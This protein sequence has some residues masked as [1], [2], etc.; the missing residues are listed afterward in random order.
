MLTLTL[1]TGVTL[2][3]LCF[4]VYALLA[5]R[6]LGTSAS[7]GHAESWYAA[8]LFFAVYSANKLVQGGWGIAAFVAGSDAPV[9]AG[10]LRFA[11]VFNHSRTFLTFVLYGTLFWISYSRQLTLRQRIVAHGAAAA[12]LGLGG[13]YGYFEGSL[14]AGRHYTATAIID[15]GGFIVLAVLLFVLMLRDTID[16]LLW[17]AL[18]T[19]GF[20]SIFGVIFLAALAWADT[21]GGWTPPF[22]S[23]ELCRLCFAGMM[24]WFAYQ[25]YRYAGQRRPVPGL[26]QAR[27]QP[28][29]SFG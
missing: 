8:G 13:T 28:R 21:P 6:R 23:I 5:A 11:P 2:F 25:R 15:A 10:Y 4:S 19:H 12:A 18:V 17:F 7:A 1:Q 27:Q 14:Q 22:W 24:A 20:R 26:L 9:Y 3:L 16:R 29:P